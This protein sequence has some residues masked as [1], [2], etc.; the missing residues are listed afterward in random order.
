VT[1]QCALDVVLGGESGEI[2][3]D[4]GTE[5]LARR[6]ERALHHRVRGRRRRVGRPALAVAPDPAC[7]LEVAEPLD[8]L[9]RPAAEE[10][11]VATQEPPIGARRPSV[12]DDGLQR[13]QV[14]V[15]VVEQGEHGPLIA[16]GR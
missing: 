1:G 16:S 5:C 10:G 13:R 4:V 8:R 6:R 14:S 15:H 9:A 3:D 12:P 7:G 11:V 2:A